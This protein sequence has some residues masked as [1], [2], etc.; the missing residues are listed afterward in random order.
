MRSTGW[1]RRTSTDGSSRT[2]FK[3]NGDSKVLSFQTDGVWTILYRLHFVA[4]DEAA[5]AEKSLR[6]RRGYRTRALFPPS[7]AG[8]GSWKNPSCGV[9]YG[10]G[11][12]PARQV[13]VGIVRESFCEHRKSRFHHEF[14][15]AQGSCARSGL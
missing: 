9:G 12:G 14:C 7:G 15:R 2:C 8:S 5:A 1:C 4:A 6:Q 10:S 11:E 13:S 3:M